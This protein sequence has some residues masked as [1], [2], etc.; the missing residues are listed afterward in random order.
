[1]SNKIPSDLQWADLVSRIKAK[2]DTSSLATVATSGSYNDLSNKPTIPTVN[3][4]TIT[5]QKNGTKV[6]DFTANQATAKTINITVPTSAADVS[7]LPSSTKYG[8][9]IDFSMN[10]STYVL[11]ATLKD[12][13]GNTLGTA[14]TVDLP[15]E[16]VVVDGSY[17]STNKKI[18]LELQ[19]GSTVDIPVGDLISGLQPE[20]TSNNKLSSDLVS[21][22]GNSNKFAT[23][24]QLTK[25]D[26]LPT[27]TTIGTNLSLTSGTLSATDTTYNP[28]TGA[29]G[30]SAGT[31]GLVPAPAATDNVKYLK[32]DGTWGDPT[33]VLPMASSSTLG[34]I[35]VGT[36]LSINSSTGVLSAD[37][38]VE[39]FSAAQ[40]SDLWGE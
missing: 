4:A 39:E 13:D 1:M 31:A 16:S 22:T 23:A 38:Q 19:S 33:F 36:N 14:Q 34:G 17:D 2:A 25:L 30:S 21:D 9:T 5:I 7:A 10:S 32:G 12:Q 15:L 40:W 3:N 26:N 18:V 11:T 35:K 37:A 29:D 8:A 27:I 28:F 24:S 20:I 6:D